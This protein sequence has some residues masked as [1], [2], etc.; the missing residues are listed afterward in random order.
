[1]SEHEMPV[2]IVEDSNP[3]EKPKRKPTE[4]QLEALKKSREMRAQKKAELDAN[5]LKETKPLPEIPLKVQ[6]NT[7]LKERAKPKTK[8]TVIQVESDDSEDEEEVKPTIIIRTGKKIKERVEKVKE[9]EAVE[10]TQ[11]I[12][13]AK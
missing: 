11:Y 5:T 8:P 12:R 4:K 2:E 1:M 6:A 10:P 7:I 13:R 9:I 3:I